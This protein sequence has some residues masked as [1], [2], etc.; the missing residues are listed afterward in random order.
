MRRKRVYKLRTIQSV[1]CNR[2]DKLLGSTQ[3]HPG[4]MT[5]LISWECDNYRMYAQML[6]I[7]DRERSLVMIVR[8]SSKCPKG[9]YCFSQGSF[10]PSQKKNSALQKSASVCVNLPPFFTGWWTTLKFMQFRMRRCAPHN[11]LNAA[12]TDGLKQ[13]SRY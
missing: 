7:K 13:A 11:L 6:T 8:S 1:V 5:N 2:H 3:L 12:G 4:S 10:I 9:Y